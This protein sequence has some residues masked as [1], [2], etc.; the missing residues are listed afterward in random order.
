MNLSQ[1]ESATNDAQ[2]INHTGEIRGGVNSTATQTTE[3]K[4]VAGVYD[5]R[6][7]VNDAVVE[8]PVN[9]Q[10]ES[11]SRTLHHNVMKRAVSD[12]PVANE[13]GS[14]VGAV[15][16]KFDKEF[17]ICVLANIKVAAFRK[18][19]RTFAQNSFSPRVVWGL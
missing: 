12:N 9:I 3:R 18:S 19:A 17:S 11:S 15:V 8:N 13:F 5:D 1:G 14:L 4:L 6:G 2:F 16:I 7:Y 10:R